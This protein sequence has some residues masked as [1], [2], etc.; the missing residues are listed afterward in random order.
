MRPELFAFALFAAGAYAG[1]PTLLTRQFDAYNTT[2][3]F[4]TTQYQ[5]DLECSTAI[6]NIPSD[7]V[8]RL[9]EKCSAFDFNSPEVV[10]CLCGDP[11]AGVHFVA[12]YDCELKTCG[13]SSSS[14]EAEIC[15]QSRSGN[16]ANTENGNGA[17]TKN[18]NGANTENGNGANTKNGDGANTKT[19]NGANTK[20]GMIHMGGG[21]ALA[22][23]GI[24]GLT[25]F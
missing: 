7:E 12:M 15:N 10:Q 13:D 6:F 16:G 1:F 21:L 25:M 9:T 24:A 8:D 19:G 17:N 22:L 14:T 18:G 11:S 20:N 5:C 2:N 3:T 4:N 23:V